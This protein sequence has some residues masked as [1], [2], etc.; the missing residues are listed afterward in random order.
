M[1]AAWMLDAAI[2]SAMVLGEPK[3]TVEALHN[4][5]QL[6]AD[7]Q[8]RGTPRTVPPTSGRNAMG[9]QPNVVP[10][11]RRSS[12]SI[13]QQMSITFEAIELQGMSATQRANAL[14]HLASLLTQAIGIVT[15]KERDDDEL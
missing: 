1:I 5:H 3:V 13:P 2:C 4:L 10:A 11:G 12:Q 15:E 8:L 6:I 14:R 7:R 9:N